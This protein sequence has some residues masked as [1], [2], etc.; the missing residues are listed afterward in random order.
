MPLHSDL[1]DIRRQEAYRHFAT[2]AP[3][4]PIFM[5]PYYLDAVC[6]P[7][8]W[9]AALAYRGNQVAGALPFFL[10]KKWGWQYVAMPLLCRFMGPYLLP[11]FRTV[12]REIPLLRELIAQLPPL[13]AFEQDFHYGAANWLPFYWAGFRQ[14]TRYSYVL[15]LTDAGTLLDNLAPDYRNSKLPKAAARV[16]VQWSGD[17]RAFYEVH[18]RSYARQGLAAPFSFELLERLDRALTAEGCCQQLW[19]IDRHS[20]A[21]HA[22]AYLIWDAQAAYYLLAGEDP[23]LRSSGA[24]ILLTWEAIQYALETLRVSQF[25]F[26]GSMIPA[27][28]RV[29]RQFGAEPRPYFR[30]QREW[31][32]LWRL[33]KMWRRLK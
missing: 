10:K 21:P 26:L 4:L 20:G 19:A 12:R 8:Q 13:A 31:S 22:V 33:G 3:D 17:L 15:P 23:A 6:G 29:R 32:W 16:C 5:K 14:T 7:E 30:V 27:I 2:Q 1:H 28:E 18:N 25:D 9:S 24:G 11:E